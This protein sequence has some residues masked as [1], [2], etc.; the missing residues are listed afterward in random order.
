MKKTVF[1]SI[2]GLALFGQ[3]TVANANQVVSTFDDLPLAPG[4]HY[5]PG[6]DSTFKSGLATFTHSYDED[7]GS[8]DNFVYS[9]ESNTTTAGFENQFSAITGSG[10]G[11]TGNYGLAYVSSYTGIAPAINFDIPTL[12]SGAYFTNT[13][14]ATLSMEQGD[15]FAKKF[16]GD[17]G[18]DADWFKLVITGIDANGNTAGEVDFFLADYR[19]ADNAQDY[20]V[21]D[22]A[23]VD[24]TSFGEVASLQFSMQSSDFGEYGI[25]TPTYFAVDNIIANVAAVPEPSSYALM[26]AGLGLIGFVARR[27]QH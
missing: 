10:Y 1:F 7:Y 16:G 22:W 19:F 12:I 17:S 2:I 24:F 11:S 3:V 8:W 21:K 20:I 27:R 14:Y 25:N 9:N 4:S 15:S 26:L 23:Y 6:A 13:T 5:F 18:N